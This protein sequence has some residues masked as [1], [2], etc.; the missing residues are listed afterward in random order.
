[1]K[2]YKKSK[3]TNRIRYQKNRENRNSIGWLEKR[4]CTRKEPMSLGKAEMRID[5]YAA[6]GILRFYYACPFCE[7]Y[8]IT[9]NMR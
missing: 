8:H 5:E 4:T 7:K 1:M 9:K 6:K 3:S 2:V